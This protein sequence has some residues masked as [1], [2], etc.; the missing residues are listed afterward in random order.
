MFQSAFCQAGKRG[1]SCSHPFKYESHRTG[2]QNSGVTLTWTTFRLL[3]HARRLGDVVTLVTG[4]RCSVFDQPFAEEFEGTDTGGVARTFAGAVRFLTKPGQHPLSGE[5]DVARPLGKQPVD[6]GL[7][8]RIRQQPGTL[9]IRSLGRVTGADGGLRGVHV[10]CVFAAEGRLFRGHGFPH[11]LA[12]CPA[13]FRRSDVC[14][15]RFGPTG[16]RSA[17]LSP[18]DAPALD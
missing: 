15:T 18:D 16:S 2:N 7:H 13:T 3:Q 14:G 6:L 4:E 9:A 12:S 17:P 1:P 10:H 5:V 11:L 8:L